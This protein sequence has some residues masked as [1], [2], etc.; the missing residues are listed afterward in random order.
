MEL[1]RREGGV[2]TVGDR[3]ETQPVALGT[4]YLSEMLNLHG[5]PVAVLDL[6]QRLGVQHVM[7][8]LERK[9][10]V[11]EREGARLA[12]CVDDV[13]DPEE[14][15]AEDVTPREKLGGAEHGLLR[16]A[17]LGIARTSRGPLPL[18]DPR[19]L[20]SREMLKKLAAGLRAAG[21]RPATETAPET[22]RSPRPPTPRP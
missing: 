11:V 12:L 21:A 13:R 19:P 1:G 18:I 4:A 15:P 22:G 17:L 10:V 16:D 3:R 9:L 2:R 6:A 14:L 20:V 8:I 7:P 5:E